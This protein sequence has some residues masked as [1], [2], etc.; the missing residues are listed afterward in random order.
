MK[1]NVN[2]GFI[3]IE[4]SKNNNPYNRRTAVIHIKRIILNKSLKYKPKVSTS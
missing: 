2:I 4:G 3:Q 1:R